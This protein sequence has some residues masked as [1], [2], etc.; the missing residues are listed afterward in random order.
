MPQ[1]PVSQGPQVRLQPLPSMRL[2]AANISSVSQAIGEGLQSLGASGQ[3]AA[4]AFEELN[5]RQDE[6]IVRASDA[7]A[8][9]RLAEA[10]AGFRALRG[11]QVN[12][13]QLQATNARFDSIREDA[14][15][16]FTTPRQRQLFQRVF[17]Q[18][19]AAATERLRFHT[20]EQVRIGQV[21]T[22]EAQIA[23]A[24]GL[25]VDH[26]A[27]P[28]EFSAQLE[29]VDGATRTLAQAQGWSED[30]RIAFRAEHVS[31]IHRR[32]VETLRASGEQGPRLAEAHLNRFSADIDDEDERA[33]RESLQGP[34]RQLRGIDNYRAVLEYEASNPPASA[35]APS[36]SGSESPPAPGETARPG[37]VVATG[38]AGQLGQSLTQQGLP[39]HVVAGFLGNIQ[40]ESS[41]N[42]RGS[43]DGGTAHGYA[44]WRAERVTNFQRTVGVHPRDA[45]PAQTA[46]FIKWEMDNPGQAGMTVAQ[47]DQILGARTAEEAARLID[48]FYERSDGRHREQR[49]RNARNFYEGGT[50][51]TELTVPTPSIGGTERRYQAAYELAR[52]RG[53]SQQ[54]LDEVLARVDGDARRSRELLAEQETV[55]SREV[56]AQVAE[57]GADNITSADQLGPAYYQLSPTDRLGYDSM[58]QGNVER[59]QERENWTFMEQLQRE[60]MS[61]P[62]GRDAFLSRSV[63]ETLARLSPSQ[64]QRYLNWRL[65]AEADARRPETA[66]DISHATILSVSE[67]HIIA[68]LDRRPSTDGVSDDERPG[69]LARQNQWD[70][71]VVQ[72]RERMS[73]YLRQRAQAG[74][75]QITNDE[76]YEI[77]RRLATTVITRSGARVRFYELDD[78]SQRV[79]THVPNDVI[80]EIRQRFRARY[81]RDPDGNE[82]QEIYW[83]MLR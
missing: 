51:E 33:S 46:R 74:D 18:R 40:Q 47:R 80:R 57:R 10:E 75:R 28:D 83:G 25:A 36:A 54:D 59:R 50:S 39:A 19:R 2:E 78:P 82:V 16:E 71:E 11:V 45:T 52:Q 58:I 63:P 6:N 34:L 14:M 1:V 24:A 29:T 9:P 30:R 35:N 43:G 68:A 49:A 72:F 48:R 79:G 65:E 77:A 22:S 56:A 53:W 44:Q 3:Q 66:Q 12:D 64:E 7:A 15:R 21:E 67:P 5:A 38:V 61:G 32:I 17:E 81:G 73:V 26:H 13:Q 60:L 41:F 27:D 23:T 69:V 70:R 37:R 20:I 4:V 55:A 8:A 76:I 62:E 42:P 31:N